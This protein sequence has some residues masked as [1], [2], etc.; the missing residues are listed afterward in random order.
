MGHYLKRWADH[1]PC[2]GEIK[3]GTTGLNHKKIVITSNYTPEELWPTD[4]ILAEALRRRFK[5]I[6]IL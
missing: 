5:M 1:Y 4:P 6:N 2:T 3:G